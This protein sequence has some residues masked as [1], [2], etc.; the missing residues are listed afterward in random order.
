ML[1]LNDTVIGSQWDIDFSMQA[2]RLNLL[3]GQSSLNGSHILIKF[4]TVFKGLNKVSLK[5]KQ[6]PDFP[7]L[8]LSVHEL[9]H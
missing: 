4:S 5:M 7:L 3:L 9:I 2:T 8:N 1:S 6:Q